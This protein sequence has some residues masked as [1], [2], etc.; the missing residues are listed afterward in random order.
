M[1]YIIIL[2]TIFFCLPVG[3]FI[4]PVSKMIFPDILNLEYKITSISII[5]LFFVFL[6]NYLIVNIPYSNYILC[7]IVGIS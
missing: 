7:V 6:L 1:T 3:A 5:I 4:S 2:A